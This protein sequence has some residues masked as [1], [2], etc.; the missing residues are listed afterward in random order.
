M[1]A[2]EASLIAPTMETRPRHQVGGVRRCVNSGDTS[3]CRGRLERSLIVAT[4]F[5]LPATCFRKR[6]SP[7]R[8]ET[9]LR[10]S[11]EKAALHGRAA[12]RQG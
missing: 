3:L 10:G 6:S 1:I 9:R 4:S 5:Q 8:V 12:A 7:A 2:M 11:V